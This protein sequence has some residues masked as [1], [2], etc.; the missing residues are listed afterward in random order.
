MLLLLAFVIAFPSIVYATDWA[1]RLVVYDGGT[2]E[3]TD[4]AVDES[5]I[6]KKIGKVTRY[7]DMRSYGGNFSNYFP[8]GT[9]YFEI[10]GMSISQEIAVKTGDGTYV[11]A[12][13]RG[14]HAAKNPT[15]D[16]WFWV[17]L[18][19]GAF[20][21]VIVVFIYKTLRMKGKNQE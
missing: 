10:T 19:F 15:G 6:G 3:V 16:V 14:P 17:K 7:S 12:V 8:K 9:A 2:Y 1:Y 20:G 4:E 21:V 18:G 5:R 13:Y 11:K